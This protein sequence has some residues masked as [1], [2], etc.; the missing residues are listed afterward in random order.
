MKDFIIDMLEI[1]FE[2][3][4]EGLSFLFQFLLV[5]SFIGGTS[6]LLVY[7]INKL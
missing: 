2:L 1:L 5:I 7:L 6:A 3:V 4:L